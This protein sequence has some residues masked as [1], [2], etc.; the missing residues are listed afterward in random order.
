MISVVI[1]KSLRWHYSVHYW[2]LC[3]LPCVSVLF[4]LIS[5]ARY[6]FKSPSICFWGT[7]YDVYCKRVA[8]LHSKLWRRGRLRLELFAS[9]VDRFLSR[10]SYHICPRT[11][12]FGDAQLYFEKAIRFSREIL[13]FLAAIWSSL[14]FWSSMY[15]FIPPLIVL[16]RL[17]PQDLYSSVC[18]LCC[19]L[20]C[21]C[22]ACCHCS[23]KFRQ[24]HGFDPDPTVNGKCTNVTNRRSCVG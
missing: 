2:H 21:C 6:V 17:V 18:W 3:N 13:M 4:W 9:T 12:F 24:D 1:C 7:E 8:Y 15:R 23:A 20:C 5:I 16:V 14:C 11:L 10:V 22:V 19:V